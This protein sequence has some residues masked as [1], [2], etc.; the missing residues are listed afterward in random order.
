MLFP[1]IPPGDPVF[2]NQ[3]GNQANSEIRRLLTLLNNVL[4]HLCPILAVSKCLPRVP[5]DSKVSGIMPTE[6]KKVETGD[7]IEQGVFGALLSSPGVKDG[8]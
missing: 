4:S 1:A 6:N 8:S 7:T 2:T 3:R 5:G